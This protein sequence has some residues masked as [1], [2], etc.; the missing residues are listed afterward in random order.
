MQCKQCS[1]DLTGKDYKM[2]AE[3]PFCPDC[4]GQLLTKPA[5]SSKPESKAERKTDRV[6]EYKQA[7]ITKCHLCNKEIVSDQYKKIGIWV[8]CPDCH[9]DL[10]PRPKPPPPTRA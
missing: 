5:E 7:E 8:F 2:V 4:F 6:V 10:T 9:L 3:W 1:T